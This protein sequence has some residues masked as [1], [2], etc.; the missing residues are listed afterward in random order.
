MKLPIF[1]I[2]NISADMEAD[3]SL[4]YVHL[5]ASMILC[6]KMIYDKWTT[7]ITNWISATNVIRCNSK[8]CWVI[9]V[10]IWALDE[11]GEMNY[12]AD[13]ALSCLRND[14]KFIHLH[15]SDIKKTME[16]S[17]GHY[18][19]YVTIISITFIFY[20]NISNTDVIYNASF[21]RYCIT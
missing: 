17:I 2:T 16:W 18:G 13:A 9:N 6:D 20:L 5:D 19:I 3:Y 11:D 12:D 7:Y 15:I 8:K 21:I 14:V 1:F 4:F 10:P